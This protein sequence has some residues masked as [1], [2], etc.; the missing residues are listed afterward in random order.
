MIPGIHPFGSGL[1]SVINHFC[2]ARTTRK[3][4][5][6][7]NRENKPFC[8]EYTPNNHKLL[9]FFSF[10]SSNSLIYFA[11]ASRCIKSS[12]EVRNS[13]ASSRVALH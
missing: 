12:T 1:D 6:R 5:V 4:P 13:T 3:L 2:Y 7:H 10:L 9:S 11:N 8:I